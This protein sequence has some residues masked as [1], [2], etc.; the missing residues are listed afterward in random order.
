VRG[1]GLCRPGRRVAERQ[2][3]AGH[4]DFDVRHQ[5][6]LTLPAIRRSASIGGN[7]PEDGMNEETKALA[8]A[9]LDEV[10]LGEGEAV[11]AGTVVRPLIRLLLKRGLVSVED[12][13]EFIDNAILDFEARDR[14]A[15]EVDKRVMAYARERLDLLLTDLRTYLPPDD[16]PLPEVP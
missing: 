6:V 15:R 13:A 4:A 8:N 3:Q 2:L 7:N 10:I 1:G 16:Q 11:F 12:V 14:T 5:R 9:L